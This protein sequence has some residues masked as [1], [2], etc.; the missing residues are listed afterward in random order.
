MEILEKD[1]G[2]VMKKFLCL[3]LV[4]VFFTVMV[5]SLVGQRTAAKIT[6]KV[7]DDMGKA[8]KGVVVTSTN[9]TN[10]NERTRKTSKRGKFRFLSMTPDV[11]QL[12]FEKE[13]FQTHII[14]FILKTQQTA[15]LKIKLLIKK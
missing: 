15:S 8:I 11:Y 1:K 10:G 5:S 4:I 14:N 12:N 9:A 3:I 7:I 2:G 13:G 6:G